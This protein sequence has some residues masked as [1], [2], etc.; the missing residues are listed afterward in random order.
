MLG[1]VSAVPVYCH[2]CLFMGVEL[3]FKDLGCF[4]VWLAGAG[5]KPSSP[6]AT[7]CRRAPRML[8]TPSIPPSPPHHGIAA[9]PAQPSSAPSPRFP[10]QQAGSGCCLLELRSWRCP[11]LRKQETA[12][13]C[14][15]CCKTD[16][17]FRANLCTLEEQGGC[18]AS[19]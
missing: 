14:F 4:G 17:K 6:F 13:G 15:H 8:A 16:L 3:L 18:R 12:H 9:P 19:Q 2:C 1:W 5:A 7:G 11:V 10:G